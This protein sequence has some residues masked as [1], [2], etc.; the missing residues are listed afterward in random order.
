MKTAGV[1]PRMSSVFASR[2]FRLFYAG[3]AASYV[4]DG[5]RTIAVPLLVF[6][7]SGSALNLGLSYGIEFFTF[8]VFSVIGGSLADRLDR[9]RLLIACDAVRCLILAAFA[10]GDWQGW[11]TVPLIYVGLVVHA[12]CGAIFNNGQASSIP[13]VLGKERAT[14]AV[15]FLEGTYQSINVIAPPIGAA[16]FGLI[17]PLFALVANAS[18]YVVS[19]LSLRLIRDL[20]PETRGSIPK[21]SELL[22]DIGL[23]FRFLTSDPELRFMSFTSFAAIGVGMIGWTVLVPFVER[24]LGGSGVAVGFAFAAMGLGSALGAVL[25][26]AP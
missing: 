24:D 10:L 6:K 18:T 8:G 13:Y 4:G 11:L 5:L 3:Q 26:D 1:N 23:G 15:A 17:G 19:L 12:A 14:S 25:V 16:L 20:G 21:L 22:A 9:K 7:L 2:D